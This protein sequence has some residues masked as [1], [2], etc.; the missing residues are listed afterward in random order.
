MNKVLKVHEK[1]NVVTVLQ[2]LKKGETFHIDDMEIQ[3][4][5]E[6]PRFHKI[7][8]SDIPKG[9]IVY[10]YGQIIGDALA[11]IHKGEHVHIHNMESTRGR[12]DKKEK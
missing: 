1:D 6:I 7:A 8:I 3:V 11:N 12:G 10:K 5:D 9:G 4:S 2:V